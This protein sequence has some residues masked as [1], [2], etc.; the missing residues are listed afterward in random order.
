MAHDL[1]GLSAA[2]S[3][4]MQKLRAEHFA[5]SVEADREE[6]HARL[7]AAPFRGELVAARVDTLET[8]EQRRAFWMNI[9]NA[10]VSLSIVELGLRGSILLRAEFYIRTAIEIGGLGFSL[11][12]IENGVL[13][14]NRRPR[15]WPL[16]PFGRSDPRLAHC[17]PQPEPRLCFAL[18]K[19]VASSPS[20]RVF[21]PRT[22]GRELEAAEA[23]FSAVHF[24]ADSGERRICCSRLYGWAR[25][26]MDGRWLDDPAYRGWKVSYEPFDWR[27]SSGQGPERRASVDR[28]GGKANE[29]TA[30]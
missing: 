19:G 15:A 14:A 3:H 25:R 5:G 9:Y 16:R 12:A 18:N 17:L 30:R 13:R 23:E 6:S 28:R 27:V 10:C 11:D 8:I 2:F 24:I 22:I 21:E 7:A 1:A 29:H 20:L 26:D 4:A